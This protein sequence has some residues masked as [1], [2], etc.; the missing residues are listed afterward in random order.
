MVSA[1][2]DFRYSSAHMHSR[3]I[4]P[5]TLLWAHPYSMH[6]NPR[7]FSFSDVFWP[8]RWLVA[9]GKLHLEDAR[10]PASLDRATLGHTVVHNEDA[11]V[12]FGHGPLNCVGKGLALQELRMM[13]CAL[14]QKFDFAL[15]EGWDPK[16]FERGMKWYV[17][18]GIPP[19]PVVLR[20]RM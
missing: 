14:M 8:E 4:P 16:E 3:H 2:D 18:T 19:L 9:A 11:F 5:G 7:S 13:V 20:T 12:P 15:Q 6:R 1:H 10:L 17:S